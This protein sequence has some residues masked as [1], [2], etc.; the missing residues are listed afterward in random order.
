MATTI[1]HCNINI[2]TLASH[3]IMQAQCIAGDIA[4][5]QDE[6]G[7]WTNFVGEQGHIDSYDVPFDSYNKALWAAKAAAEFEAM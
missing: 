6:N 7:W 3:E 4:I 5:V 2:V 1:R